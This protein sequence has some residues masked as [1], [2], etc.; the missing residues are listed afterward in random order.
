MGLILLEQGVNLELISGL[1]PAPGTEA[2]ALG[3]CF[4]MHAHYDDFGAQGW[5]TADLASCSAT[6]C[7]VPA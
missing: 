3:V 1:M 2:V 7:R 6:F 5:R 4:L